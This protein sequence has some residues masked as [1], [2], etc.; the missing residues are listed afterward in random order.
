M[1]EQLKRI[2]VNLTVT[3]LTLCL[4]ILVPE[5]GQ[6]IRYALRFHSSYWLFYGFA[7]KPPNYDEMQDKYMAKKQNV[8]I[9]KVGLVSYDGYNKN[10]PLNPEYRINSLGFRGGEVGKEKAGYR[11]AVLGGS[12]TFCL[13]MKDGFTYP[14][15]LS[16]YTG[17]E[18][19][20]AGVPAAT[21]QDIA[22]LFEKEILPLKPDMV[23]INSV[24]NNLY[25]FSMRYSGEG[26]LYDINRFLVSYSLFYMTLREKLAASAADVHRA[27]VS[28]VVN[29]F[30]KDKEFWKFLKRNYEKIISLSR[31]SGIK[32]VIVD[33]PRWFRKGHGALFD[34]RMKG[35]Y[36]KVNDLF[37]TFDVQLVDAASY[38]EAYPDKE[39]VFSGDGLHLTEAGNEL[40]AKIILREVKF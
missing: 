21:I 23:I 4:I 3:A 12:T 7:P 13:G 37:R 32:V 29:G 31:A 26:P 11:I 8:D 28:A 17:F 40:L 24:Y 33:E 30:K 25:I 18:V 39:A 38:F 35:V 10:N 14:D 5:C 9:I 34:D 19:I 36:K 22:N 1:P 27:P 15:L 2:V 20:N 6:R 16:R